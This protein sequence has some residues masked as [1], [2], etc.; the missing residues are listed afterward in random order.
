VTVKKPKSARAGRRA[1]ARS[2]K[3][4]AD[5]RRRLAKLEPG[6]APDR[7]MDVA[8]ASVVEARVEAV[9]CIF[10]GGRVRTTE[11]RAVTHGERRL[12]VAAVRC[13]RCGSDRTLYF[14]I[15]SPLPS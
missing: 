6:G 4:L 9:P 7:P 5:Q 12:R 2:E 1:A 8:S 3:K 13:V 11:H 10:C 15:G 14:R